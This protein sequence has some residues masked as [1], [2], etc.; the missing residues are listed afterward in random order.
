MTADAFHTGP[1]AFTTLLPEMP[2]EMPVPAGFRDAV[3]QYCGF[4]A[5]VTSLGPPG[6]TIEGRYVVSRQPG[7]RLFLKVFDA[8]IAELQKHSARVAAHLDRHGVP[9]VRSL[10]GEPRAFAPGYCGELFPFLDARFSRCDREELSEIGS[11]LARTHVALASFDG[12]AEVERSASEM[13]RR[14]ATAAESILSGSVPHPQFAEP[15]R[16]AAQ[17]YLSSA[18]VIQQPPQMV[19]GDCNYTN[20]LVE[21][22]SGRVYLI[23]FEESRAAWLNPMF[24]VA[25]VIER[26]VLVP[27]RADGMDNASA[28]LAA[29]RDAG[30]PL[31]PA[32]LKAV[33]IASNDRALMIMADKAT[34]GLQ[35]PDA[36]WQK[37]IGLKTLVAEQAQLLDRLSRRIATGQ[38]A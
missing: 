17:G 8:R 24:D 23:D 5:E 7:E 35:L 15:L 6:P 9:V 36:E 28:F 33:L 2:Q 11:V 1:P 16:A 31:T 27:S 4:A 3:S 38:F 12:A 20:V 14:L 32:D 34:Q 37:F 18:H 21:R 10:E 13:H 25:K 22:A 26:F 19:H 30:G 29:Y